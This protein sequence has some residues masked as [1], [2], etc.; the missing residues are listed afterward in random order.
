MN[1]R[2]IL[3]NSVLLLC[4]IALVA[5]EQYSSTTIQTELAS[6]AERNK[7]IQNKLAETQ[8]A[9]PKTDSALL[10]SRYLA[11]LDS[12]LEIA[13]Q[14]H[15]HSSNALKTISIFSVLISIS[16]VWSSVR[17]RMHGLNSPSGGTL[18][19]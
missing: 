2:P 17:G 18:G 15:L 11:N 13:R 7:L 16:L 14:L 9:S 4:L 3:E 8:D 12:K 6:L 10:T 1:S 19:K 5:W